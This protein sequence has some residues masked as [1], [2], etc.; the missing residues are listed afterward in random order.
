M[1]D[2]PQQH[3]VDLGGL[4]DARIARLAVDFVQRRLEF[5]V[6]DLDSNFAGL[7]QYAGRRPATLR[8]TDARVLTAQLDACDGPLWVSDLEVDAD[9]AGFRACL[10]LTSGDRL[11]WTFGA[12]E[13][14]T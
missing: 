14:L 10:L 12:L 7:P 2:N 8:F 9:P 5:D 1:I 3:F 4:H 6:A 13:V 11:A